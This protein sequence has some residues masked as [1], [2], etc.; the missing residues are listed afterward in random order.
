MIESHSSGRALSRVTLHL[1]F[2]FLHLW[3]QVTL[4]LLQSDKLLFEVFHWL[5]LATSSL[6]WCH[7]LFALLVFDCVL[8]RNV[9]QDF[10]MMSQV[11]QPKKWLWRIPLL[12]FLM[13]FV[14]IDYWV[15]RGVVNCWVVLPGSLFRTWW[16]P[17][18]LFKVVIWRGLEHYGLFAFDRSIL[19]VVLRWFSIHLRKLRPR[20]H[21][22]EVWLFWNIASIIIVNI[23]YVLF[24]A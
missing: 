24:F 20:K 3:L 14:E 2:E 15:G 21:F 12:H 17:A 5:S 10:S 6:G 22:A 1:L 19:T 4:V 13:S 23:V 7:L 8:R 11:T 16:T 18:V 9:V